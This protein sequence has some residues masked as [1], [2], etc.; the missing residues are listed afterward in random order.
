L[1]KGDGTPYWRVPSQK[2]L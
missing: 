1:K 2:I